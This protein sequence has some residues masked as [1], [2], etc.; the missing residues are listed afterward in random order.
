M[1]AK[2]DEVK[3]KDEK[4]ID[5]AIAA[6][7]RTHPEQI[8]DAMGDYAIALQ[9]LSQVGDLEIKP[10]IDSLKRLYVYPNRPE[11]NSFLID[12]HDLKEVMQE[13]RID[14]VLATRE[15]AKL[16]RRG[17]KQLGEAGGSKKWP[18]FLVMAIAIFILFK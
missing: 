6:V 4:L 2:F 17:V 8:T 5:K 15:K 10:I 3:S 9:H 1:T 14:A 12:L 11:H 18:F 16:A 7:E 13:L